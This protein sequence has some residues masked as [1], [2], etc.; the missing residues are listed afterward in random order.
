MLDNATSPF[1]LANSKTA[2]ET[3]LS[4]PT[5]STLVTTIAVV[6]SNITVIVAVCVEYGCHHAS[7][8]LNVLQSEL[9]PPPKGKGLR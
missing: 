4:T 6:T 1:S 3:D 9:A 8:L 7:G 2:V 5:D